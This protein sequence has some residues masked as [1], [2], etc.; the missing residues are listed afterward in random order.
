MFFGVSCA[1]RKEKEKEGR[2][3]G[4]KDERY[5]KLLVV[6]NHIASKRPSLLKNENDEKCK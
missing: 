5:V 6:G 3:R 1:G 2:K 4:R